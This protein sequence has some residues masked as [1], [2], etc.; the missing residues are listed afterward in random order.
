MAICVMICFCGLLR[1]GEA[2]GLKVSDVLV[3]APGDPPLVLLCL[4]RTKRGMEQRVPLRHPFVVETIRWYFLVTG[5]QPWEK[6][7]IGLTY[8]RVSSLLRNACIFFDLLGVDFRTHSFRRGGATA[9]FASGVS[10]PEILTH[11]RWSSD[12]S[13]KEYIRRGEAWGMALLNNLSDTV[14][15][16][17]SNYASMAVSAWQHTR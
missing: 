11:G 8:G 6:F 4:G 7:L 9:L 3:S 15:I 14:M 10:W 2:L 12:R 16:K 1:I 5:L 13:A 17:I